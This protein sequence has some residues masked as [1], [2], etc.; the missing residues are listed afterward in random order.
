[1]N[2]TPVFIREER[3]SKLQ[4]GRKDRGGFTLIELLV[5]IA[6]IAILAAL[7]LPV[8][9]KA[10]AK[11]QGIAC[12]NNNKQLMLAWYL[13][14]DDF[15][16]WVCPT[17]GTAS[18]GRL[19]NWVLGN[20]LSSTNQIINGLLFRY[21]KNLGLY[22]CPGD[23]YVDPTTHREHLR[24]ISMNAWM[25]PDNNEGLVGGGGFK[26]FTKQS[27]ISRPALI[28][29]TM[30]ENPTSIND[31]WFVVDPAGHGNP[32][33]WI[34][35]PASYHNGAGG[36]SFADGHASIKKWREAAVLRHTGGPFF[37]ADPGEID[38]RW[39]QDLTTTKY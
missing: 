30:D 9:S 3:F 22:K 35:C 38:C 4:S 1:M 28:W 7:L 33:S 12:I 21:A 18:L 31:G 23:H 36:L 10:K 13:Y 17:G 39:I 19:D 6:I 11:A 32:P 16:D 26:L 8:L 5:V 34:D 20:D 25:N 2:A 14:S 24:S 15:R 27:G 29:V 37:A